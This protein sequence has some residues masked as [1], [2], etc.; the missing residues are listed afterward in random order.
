MFSLGSG[1]TRHACILP[2][3]GLPFFDEPCRMLSQMQLCLQVCIMRNYHPGTIIL[4]VAN[5][6]I[7]AAALEVD[8]HH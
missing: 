1:S 2:A 3:L 6:V 4:S 8:T 7:E 5:L